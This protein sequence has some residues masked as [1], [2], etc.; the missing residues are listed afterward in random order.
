MYWPWT[1]SA[2]RRAA[3]SLSLRPPPDGFPER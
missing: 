1:L 2:A 3:E